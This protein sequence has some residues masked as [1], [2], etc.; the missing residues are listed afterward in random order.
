[1]IASQLSTPLLILLSFSFFCSTQLPNHLF[2]SS[3]LWSSSSKSPRGRYGSGCFRLRPSSVSSFTRH[4][5]I[6]SR[7]T[8]YYLVPIMCLFCER[9]RQ[10]TDDR[11]YGWRHGGRRRRQSAGRR[12]DGSSG[13]GMMKGDSQPKWREWDSADDK[14][15][16]EK[17]T[18]KLFCSI[19][20]K[21]ER[22]ICW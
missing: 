16:S 1:M 5:S 20:L 6:D 21:L 22:E 3:M 13:N 19:Q 18:R 8:H 15:R 7:R 12:L 2:T 10:K 9:R 17:T 14:D 11:I 4:P